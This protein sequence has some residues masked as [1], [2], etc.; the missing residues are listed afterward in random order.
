MMMTIGK[1]SFINNSKKRRVGLFTPIIDR[2]LV[3]N[4]KKRS[5]RLPKNAK[6]LLNRTIPGDCKINRAIQGE[7]RSSRARASP[8]GDYAICFTVST[9]E[10]RIAR[11]FIPVSSSPFLLFSSSFPTGSGNQKKAS[12]HQGK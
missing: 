5:E 9:A 6:A 3:K 2:T 11:R 8:N 1:I 7:K 10:N 12:V 4:N